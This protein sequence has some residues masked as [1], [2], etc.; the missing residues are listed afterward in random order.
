VI[1]AA[2]LGQPADCTPQGLAPGLQTGMPHRKPAPH[3]L[4]LRCPCFRMNSNPRHLMDGK[5][6]HVFRM[7]LVTVGS[8][9]YRRFCSHLGCLL[10]WSC[11]CVGLFSCRWMLP[12]TDMDLDVRVARARA[13]VTPGPFASLDSA[14]RT[15][16]HVCSAPVPVA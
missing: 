5:S 13:T 11:R 3:R 16:R 10:A 6:V 14:F 2:L 8:L 15:A 4:G 1:V 7:S 12:A 9:M